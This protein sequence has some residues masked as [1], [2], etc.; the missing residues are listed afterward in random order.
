MKNTLI[1]LDIIFISQ[2]LEIVDIIYAEPCEED[3]CNSF[4]PR[5]TAKYILEVNGN[6]T[7]ENVPAGK[8]KL[9]TWNERYKADVVEVAVTEEKTAEIEIQLHR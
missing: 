5:E 7:I 4:I 1:P 8:H 2:N 9:I 6:F 3:I